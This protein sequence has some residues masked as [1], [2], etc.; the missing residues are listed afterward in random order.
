MTSF[1]SLNITGGGVAGRNSAVCS[2]APT[3]RRDSLSSNHSGGGSLSPFPY[4]QPSNSNG[5]SSS[6]LSLSGGGSPRDQQQL[7]LRGSELVA[8]TG[9]L[10]EMVRTNA[11][12]ATRQQALNETHAQMHAMSFF[13]HYCNGQ[14][15][16]ACGN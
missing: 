15:L 16:P 14:H 5:R 6:S 12:R 13:L 9:A 7:V 1:N 4:T 2:P 10:K 3:I 8:F 11:V